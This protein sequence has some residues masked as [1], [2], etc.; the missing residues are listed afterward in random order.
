MSE[1]EPVSSTDEAFSLKAKE[2]DLRLKE[3]EIENKEYELKHRPG[4]LRSTA[5][6]PAVIAA[7]IAAWTTVTAGMITWYSGKISADAQRIEE[8]IKKR[9]SEFDFQTGAIV[10]SLNNVDDAH[11]ATRLNLLVETGL[12]TGDLADKVKAYVSSKQPK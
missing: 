1:T 6:H 10:A 3:L 12:V 9:E 7:M 4:P 11:I 5:T 8:M 2:L